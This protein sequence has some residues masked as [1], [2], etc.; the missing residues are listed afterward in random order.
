[1]LR[2]YVTGLRE[3][4]GVYFQAKK[5]AYEV[6]RQR[7]GERGGREKKGILKSQLLNYDL[8]V[9]SFAAGGRRR[10]ARR[11]PSSGH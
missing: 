4:E 11:L 2:A 6:P 9:R 7:K 8:L 5:A 3:E 1:M 10:R